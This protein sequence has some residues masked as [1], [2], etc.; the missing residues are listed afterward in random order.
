MRKQRRMKAHASARWAKLARRLGAFCD[1]GW[2]GTLE[3][4]NDWLDGDDHA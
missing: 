3:D 4:L 1:V 2:F